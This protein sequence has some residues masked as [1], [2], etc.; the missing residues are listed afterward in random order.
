MVRHVPDRLLTRQD[1][2]RWEV[3]MDRSTG[4]PVGFALLLL[5]AVAFGWVVYDAHGKHSAEPA[6]ASFSA[7]DLRA[8]QEQPALV[9]P[10]Q[11]PGP[12]TNYVGRR[13]TAAGLHVTGVDADEGFWVEKNGQRA[14]VQIETAK[15]SPYTVRVGD[16][17]SIS[18]RVLPHNPDFPSKIFFCPGRTASANELS[19]APTHFAVLVDAVSFGTG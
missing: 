11:M 15:E 12:I 6:L 13:V 10:A 4:T 8:A 7:A 14:W 19:R 18:G 9:W 3:G 17:V 1:D 5:F 16:T 2:T